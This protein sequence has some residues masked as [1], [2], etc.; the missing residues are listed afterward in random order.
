MGIT[1]Q[2]STSGLSQKQIIRLRDK[3]MSMPLSMLYNIAN[4]YDVEIPTEK[5]DNYAIANIFI[6][7]LS[8]KSKKELLLKYGDAGRVS[9]FVYKSM[10]KT[11]EIKTILPKAQALLEYEPESE[12]MEYYPY[13][14][15]VQVDDLTQT[16]RIRF[17]YLHGAIKLIDRETGK[18]IERRQ[19]WNGVVLLKHDSTI[20]E[21][22]VKHRTMA[23][24]IS[25]KIPAHLGLEPFHALSLKD[26]EMNN[27]FVNWITSLN[28]ATIELPLRDAHASI[29]ITARKGMDL[30][31]GKKYHEELK[32][33]RLRHGHVTIKRNEQQQ[34]NFHIYFKD[35]HL[36]FTLFSSEED[37]RYIVDALEK[38]SEGYNF[39]RPDKILTE[40]FGKKT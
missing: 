11:P 5:I 38:I 22:R 35:C 32:K 30:R 7:E 23:R 37:I 4:S 9:S 17:H 8:L 36:K 2:N 29:I 14:D 3:L 1:L 19:Y 20:M 18:L 25:L 34:T 31:T 6:D 33:G 39:G 26:S 21:I 15:E 40:Y 13:V 24:R 28:S 10:K 16:L 12:L 27:K